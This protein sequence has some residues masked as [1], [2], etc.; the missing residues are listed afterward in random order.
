MTGVVGGLLI[1]YI[2][3]GGMV[4]RVAAGVAGSGS[5][6]ELYLFGVALMHPVVF[7]A[8]YYRA[9]GLIGLIPC[10]AVGW[11]MSLAWPPAI[12]GFMDRAPGWYVRLFV[13]NR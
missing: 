3:V 8:V 13:G 1:P 10:A 11:L 12:S 6:N 4:I 7:T 5:G 2:F 9:V